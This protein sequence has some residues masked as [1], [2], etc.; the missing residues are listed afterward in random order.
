MLSVA[1]FYIVMLTSIMMNAVMLNVVAPI[2][3]PGDKEAH[4]FISQ[5]VT[6]LIKT[7]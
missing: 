6:H 5:R 2:F 1:F 7:H 3:N 4:S